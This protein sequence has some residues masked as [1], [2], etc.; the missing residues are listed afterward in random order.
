[1]SPTLSALK[2]IDFT[3]NI[4]EADD[5]LWEEDAFKDMMAAMKP[6][7][8]KKTVDTVTSKACLIS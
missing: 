4:T 1:M 6:F 3:G 2:Y 7:L 5:I 8:S